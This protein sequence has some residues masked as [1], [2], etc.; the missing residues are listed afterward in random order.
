MYQQ[1]VN[2]VDRLLLKPSLHHNKMRPTSHIKF[3]KRPTGY[4][5]RAVKIVEILRNL[6]LDGGLDGCSL[7]FE[8]VVQETE[9]DV[10]H[11]INLVPGNVSS[12]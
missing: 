9:G 6:P 3:R 8:E 7:A 11:L 1:A 2:I 12:L 10:V 5:V 4:P